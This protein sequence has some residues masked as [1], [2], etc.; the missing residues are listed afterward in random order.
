MILITG[1]AGF[2]GSNI[3]N[4]LLC[5]GEPVT[6][7]DRFDDHPDKWQNLREFAPEH[8]IAPDMLDAWLRSHHIQEII[9]MGAISDTRARDVDA[10]LA[11]NLH[12]SQKLWRFACAE[13]I[14][15]I[16]ASSAATYGS[17]DT[18]S[19]SNDIENMRLLRPQNPYGWSKWL[20]DMYALRAQA[21]GATPPR[22]AGLKF[23]NVFG[24]NEWHKGAQSSVIRQF[25]HQIRTT[26]NIRLFRS[27]RTDIRYDQIA[28][29][30]ISVQ[31]CINLVMWLRSQPGISGIF[32]CGTGTPTSFLAIAEYLRARYP[33]SDTHK[34]ATIELVP[35]PKDIAPHYQYYTCADTSRLHAKG[36]P[37][38]FTNI[39]AAIDAYLP[40][41]DKWH[42]DC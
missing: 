25:H 6:I 26:G 31:D 11:T 32:N 33:H 41:L 38:P 29:D 7:C 9:H 21:Q 30:F 1:G 22:W 15:F 17:A 23:F 8:I 18:C 40:H 34:P 39:N 10:L 5:R 37:H 27:P 3:A 2:I 36:Y 4:H 35:M 28:R 14:G 42:D 19:D 20:F 24:P 12:L 16:Y 13:K